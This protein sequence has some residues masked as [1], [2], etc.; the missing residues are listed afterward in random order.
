MRRDENGYIVVET[1]GSFLLFVF[2]MISILSLVNIVT[3][4]ARIHYAM[5]QTAETV[6]M[7]AYTLEVLGVADHMQNSA[8]Q[9]QKA[10]TEIYTLQK[11]INEVLDQIESLNI[12]GI[13]ASGQKT[14]D[15][16]SDFVS[17]AREDP[18]AILQEFMNLGLQQAGSLAFESLI[19]SPLMERYLSSGTM[20]GDEFLR[21][22]QVI[23]GIDG[24]DFADVDLVS[25]DTE[26]GRFTSTANN[27]SSILTANGNVKL[28]VRYKID[29]TF[30]AL[31]LPFGEL[32]VTQEVMTKAWLNGLGEGYTKK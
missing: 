19:V 22:F 7:Y 6:S 18:K 29:Y 14:Y 15:Q 26:T 23:D 24:L 1:I 4:Q 30:G 5:T 28:T 27:D 20:S 16:V 17:S 11:N 32:E 12:D 10:E 8:Q 3:V 13:K 31:P 2:L 25:F 9:A 21:A